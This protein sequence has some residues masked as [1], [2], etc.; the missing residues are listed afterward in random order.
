[1]AYATLLECR[2][3]QLL[4]SLPVLSILSAVEFLM[5]GWLFPSYSLKVKMKRNGEKLTTTLP[6]D[7]TWDVKV[8][9]WKLHVKKC[10]R[11]VSWQI[12]LSNLGTTVFCFMFKQRTLDG[13]LC[14]LS[15]IPWSSAEKRRN[16]FGCVSIVSNTVNFS[17]CSCSL[18]TIGFS[19]VFLKRKNSRF[20]TPEEVRYGTTGTLYLWPARVATFLS[21]KI[22][23]SS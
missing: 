21:T 15:I 13:V 22:S 11:K 10:S 5:R 17:W 20:A 4:Q 9:T 16:V 3:C 6:I 19:F 12:R 8:W 23:R 2:F 1:M 14:G 18:S 7:H